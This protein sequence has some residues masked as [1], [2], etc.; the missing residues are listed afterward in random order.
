MTKTHTLA[1]ESHGESAHGPAIFYGESACDRG[2][3]MNVHSHPT[4]HMLV[5]RVRHVFFLSL[6]ELY[7]DGRLSCPTFFLT[8]FTVV[9]DSSLVFRVVCGCLRP[10]RS[11]VYVFDYFF[12]VSV[13]LRLFQRA[14]PPACARLDYW[15][16]R[17]FHC[18]YRVRLF[19]GLSLCFTRSIVYAFSEVIHRQ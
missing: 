4:T 1:A 19:P 9:R 18:F 15:C 8:R 13:L 5:C 12:A 16:A 2:S 7:T 11:S 3:S 6:R 17:A 10:F 14:R